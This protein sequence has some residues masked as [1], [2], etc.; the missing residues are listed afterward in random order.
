MTKLPWPIGR[1]L[2]SP[3][4]YICAGSTIQIFEDPCAAKELR[5]RVVVI[6]ADLHLDRRFLQRFFL[7]EAAALQQAFMWARRVMPGAIIEP[8]CG[9]WLATNGS[10]S[11]TIMVGED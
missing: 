7:S 9:W 1:R 2:T 5:W 8:H 6:F 11:I 10:F 4:G 3:H